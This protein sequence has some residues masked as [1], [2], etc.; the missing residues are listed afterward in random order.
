MF[1]LKSLSGV[2]ISFGADRIYDVLEELNLFP[3]NTNMACKALFVNFGEK[4]QMYC[5]PVIQQLRLNKIACELYPDNAK[6]KK[7]FSYADDKQIPYVVIVGE[8]EMKNKSFMLKN[9]KNGEQKEVKLDELI[10]ILIK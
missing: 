8:N 1:G 7:Q 10:D 3:E 2:G 9:M 5:L 4:E 6:M